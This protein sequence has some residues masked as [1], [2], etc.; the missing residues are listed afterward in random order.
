MS[1][2]LYQM[3]HKTCNERYN[4]SYPDISLH[5]LCILE[6]YM[7]L[8]SSLFGVFN[9]GDPSSIHGLGRSAGE[10]IGYLKSSILGL[11]WWLS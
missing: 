4:E 8:Q 2:V 10:E 3:L 9:A 6:Y 5:H 7:S 11:P 1:H